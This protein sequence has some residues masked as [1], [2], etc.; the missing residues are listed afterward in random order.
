MR[1][2]RRHRFQK[3]LD[4][5]RA[6]REKHVADARVW[7][8]SLGLRVVDIRKA[9]L[10]LSFQSIT[11]IGLDQHAFIDIANLSH[12]ALD[13]LVR[14]SDNVLSSLPY[15]LSHCCNFWSCWA[16]KWREQNHRHLAHNIS[17][18][19]VLRLSTHQSMGCQFRWK[20]G[21]CAQV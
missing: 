9:C 8:S 21:L 11:A 12:N 2:R 13:S 3:K 16:R 1:E 10:S 14:S 6:V 15:Q 17:S 18:H 7:A 5:I 4:S 20:V 19:H